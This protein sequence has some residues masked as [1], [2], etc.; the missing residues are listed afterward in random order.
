M[1]GAVASGTGLSL[2]G[3]QGFSPT[4]PAPGYKIKARH[5]LLIRRIELT[6]WALIVLGL[7]QWDRATHPICCIKQPQACDAEGR[8]ICAGGAA[9]GGGR[10][11]LLPPSPAPRPHAHPRTDEAP[12]RYGGRGRAGHGPDATV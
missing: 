3:A 10:L 8:C 12:Q 11:I 9:H 6:L 5:R 2:L 4:I 1:T 7:R